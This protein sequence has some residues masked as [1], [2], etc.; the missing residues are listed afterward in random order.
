[1]AWTAL[2]DSVTLMDARK[3]KVIEQSSPK[4]TH[5]LAEA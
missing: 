5:E 1:M 4:H 3:G 2:F